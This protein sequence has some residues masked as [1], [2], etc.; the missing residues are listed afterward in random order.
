MVLTKQKVY[1]L[2]F[3]NKHKK[4]LLIISLKQVLLQSFSG[5][6]SIVGFRTSELVLASR[7][8]F[9]YSSIWPFKSKKVGIF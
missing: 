5:Q 1:W 2:L 9:P 3:R 4:T 7:D 8:E 6:K